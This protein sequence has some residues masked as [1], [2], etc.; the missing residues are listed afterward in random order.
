MC[1]A[2]L[3]F[4][5][6]DLP[7]RCLLCNGVQYNGSFSCWKC[8]QKGETAKRGKGHTHVFPYIPDQPK[9]PRRTVHDVCRDAQKAMGNLEKSVLTMSQILHVPIK[10]CNLGHTLLF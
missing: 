3:L 5:T 10:K 2:Y 1:K 6:A 7:A 9:D 4:G 8:L